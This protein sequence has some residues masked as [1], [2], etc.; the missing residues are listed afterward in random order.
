MDMRTVPIDHAL[1]QWNL[2]MAATTLSVIP[3]LV[4]F[5]AAQRYFVR[6]IMLSGIK[7]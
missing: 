6:G 3:A 7:G 1:F 4:V 2:M 5:L